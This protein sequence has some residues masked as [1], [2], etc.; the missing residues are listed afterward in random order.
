[1]RAK[2][3]IQEHATK[4]HFGDWH[5]FAVCRTCGWEGTRSYVDSNRVNHSG[6]AS[7]HAHE[8]YRAQVK[9]NRWYRRLFAKD[10][11]PVVHHVGRYVG[12]KTLCCGITPE[13]TPVWDDTS[14]DESKVTCS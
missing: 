3:P 11:Q 13:Q 14:S 6:L 12:Q 2:F 1:M 5:A 7:G 4:V 8:A 9:A 10:T